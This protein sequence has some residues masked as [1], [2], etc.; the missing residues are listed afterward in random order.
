M[1]PVLQIALV[2]AL[3]AGHAPAAFASGSGQ[4]FTVVEGAAYTPPAPRAPPPPP[5]PV[6]TADAGSTLRGTLTEWAKAAGWAEPRWDAQVDYPIAGTMRFEGEFLDAVR[7][8]FAA[9]SSTQRPLQADVYVRQ[10]LIHV[11]E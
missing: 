9:H 8:I 4:A 6:W 11:T 7:E 10:N 1:K 3:A 5:T 2:A